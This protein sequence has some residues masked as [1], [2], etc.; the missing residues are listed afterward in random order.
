MFNDNPPE[1]RARRMLHV[2]QS[3]TMRRCLPD[4]RIATP[5]VSYTT[6][7]REVLEAKAHLRTSWSCIAK[8]TV[9]CSDLYKRR[10]YTTADR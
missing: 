1:S 9:T 5:V 2:L 3:F 6:Y 10:S 8:H 4:R 7:A